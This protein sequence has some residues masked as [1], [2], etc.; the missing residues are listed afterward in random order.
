MREREREREREITHSSVCFRGE[1]LEAVHVW[2]G[3]P[4]LRVLLRS[5][6]PDA[7]VT[8]VAHQ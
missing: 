1:D 4:V 8:A 3:P 2:F 7:L 5:V 6:L